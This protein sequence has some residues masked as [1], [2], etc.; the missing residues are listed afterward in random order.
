MNPGRLR[1]VC[2]T[3]LL[4]RSERAVER[5]ALLALDLEADLTLLHVA[6][7]SE[8]GQALEKTLRNAQSR[9]RSRARPPVWRLGRT[10]G[11]VMRTGNPARAVSEEI[12]DGNGVDLL[13]LGQHRRR[14]LQDVLEGT[15]AARALARRRCAVLMVHGRAVAPY[16]RVLL[17]LDASP[18]SGHTIRVAERL[19][20]AGETTVKV[21]HA[22]DP[23]YQGM[24]NLASVTSE[25]VASYGRAWR[26]EKTREIRNLLELE[27]GNPDRFSIHIEHAGAVR[28]ILN[29]VET[30]RPDLVV[31]GTRGGGRL[32]R[33][34][35]GSVANRVVQN[36]ACDVMVV[37]RPAY[38][39]CTRP[40]MRGSLS[41]NRVIASSETTPIVPP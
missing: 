26:L 6:S 20:L 22:S 35:L 9:L 32:H 7:P 30:F 17:A 25:H 24:L 33:A 38:E 41:S 1:F 11:T 18:V 34:V 31:M 5:A 4:P 21:V 37:P 29:A 10:P 16:R 2:A 15:I 12:D 19:V 28:G 13:I 36:V 14:I 8:S 3:D 23:P 27:T 40:L 39:A